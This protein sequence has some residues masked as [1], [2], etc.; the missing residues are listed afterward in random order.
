MTNKNRNKLETININ[1]KKPY[2][3]NVFSTSETIATNLS[4]NNE[5]ILDY[6]LISSEDSPDSESSSS[7]DCSQLLNNNKIIKLN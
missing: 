7:N 2:Y 6:L 3:E 1:N 5:T 4:S